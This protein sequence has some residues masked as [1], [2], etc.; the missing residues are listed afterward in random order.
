MGQLITQVAGRA[1][2]GDKPGTVIL[3]SHHCDH[4]LITTL[5]QQDYATFSDLLMAERK[6]ANLP[7]FSYLVL[8]R[9]EAENGQLAV[10]FLSFARQQAEMLLPPTGNIS[11]LGPLPAPM[12]RRGGRFRHQLTICAAE[13]PALQHLLATLCPILEQSPLAGKTRWSVDIDPQDMS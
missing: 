1:G 3:Q 11:Y 7:P 2:R 10:N 4:P 5:T 8:L 9:A 13:R 6:L 12:E